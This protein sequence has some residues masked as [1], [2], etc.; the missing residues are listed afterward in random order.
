MGILIENMHT[1]KC[2]LDGED[3]CSEQKRM[4]AGM[5]FYEQGDGTYPFATQRA[6]VLFKQAVDSLKQVNSEV[7][8][9]EVDEKGQYPYFHPQVLPLGNMI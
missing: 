6:K 9:R 1:F 7:D 8:W 2:Y 3:G 5:S 4:D